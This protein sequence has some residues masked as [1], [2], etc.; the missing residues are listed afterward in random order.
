M[1]LIVRNAP[2]VHSPKQVISGVSIAYFY[3]NFGISH[4][5]VLKNLATW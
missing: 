4:R 2:F 1:G 3:D 5:N